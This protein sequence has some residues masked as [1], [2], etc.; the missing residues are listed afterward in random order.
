M[1]LLKDIAAEKSI[2]FSKYKRR[3]KICYNLRQGC[4]TVVIE[5]SSQISLCQYYV[6]GA[7]CGCFPEAILNSIK[8]SCFNG[9]LSAPLR[10]T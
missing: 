2:T 8:N 3:R 1:L 9:C 5:K 6:M 10:Y 7:V 4:D